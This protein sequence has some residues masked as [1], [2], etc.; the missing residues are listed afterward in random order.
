MNNKPNILI[1]VDWYWP[2]YK[3]GGPIKSI[4]SIVNTLKRDFNFYIYTSCYDLDG[5]EP[6]TNIKIN[7]WNNLDGYQVYYADKNK[8]NLKSIT[9]ILKEHNYTS[10]YINSM[11]SYKFAL[12]PL[13]SIKKSRKSDIKIILAPRGMLGEGALKI[14]G[15]KK[16][17]FLTFSSYFGLYKN[18]CW[19]AT[20]EDEAKDIK[21]TFSNSAE[22][23]VATN[24]TYIQQDSNVIKNPKVKNQLDLFF[25]SRISVKKNLMY[26]IEVLEKINSMYHLNF[27]I[28][29]PIEDELYWNQIQQKIKTLPAHINVIYKGSI[30]S[31]LVQNEI[32]KHH[33]FLFPTLH[34]NFGHVIAESL[35]AGCPLIISDNTPW[36][37]LAD[38]KCG[39]DI[40]LDNKQAFVNAIQFFAEMN[41]EEYNEYSKSAIEYGLRNI[42]SPEL[43]EAN[44][45]LF[46]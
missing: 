14:K 39:F 40:S 2:A 24:I 32:K 16:Q 44:K 12:L 20:S 26:A 18:I 33:C 5:V 9:T 45:R 8:Q 30:N 13:L 31:S 6:L 1:F 23:K 10:A 3:A 27:F 22:I 17:L 37:K 7:Q 29:G 41:E 36:R 4:Y 11:F 19:H 46:L 34:E 15:V 25:I 28:Y 35:I 21:K 38:E 42:N 43:I